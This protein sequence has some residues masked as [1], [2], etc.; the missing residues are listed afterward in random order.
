MAAAQGAFS[1]APTLESLRGQ[2]ASFAADRDWDQYHTPR[3]LALALVGEVG[4]LCEIFQWQGE[5]A[6]G[7]SNFSEEKRTHLGE[8]LADVLLYL[9]RLADTCAIDLPAAAQ[10]KLQKNGE[11]YPASLVRGS[12]KKYNEYKAGATSVSEP[13]AASSNGGASESSPSKR[14]RLGGLGS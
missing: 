11:K 6:R 7:C 9:V 10:R 14:Q 3:N 1:P 13:S 8:E 5:V 12:S 4:E 2:L